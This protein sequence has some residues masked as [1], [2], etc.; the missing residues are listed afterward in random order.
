MGAELAAVR[1][2]AIV[3]FGRYA[4]CDPSLDTRYLIFVF[5]RFFS[6]CSK[7]I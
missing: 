3:C 2:E 7:H 5:L 1:A 6:H 4:S